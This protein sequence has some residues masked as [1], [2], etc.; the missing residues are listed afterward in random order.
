MNGNISCCSNLSTAGIIYAN[1]DKLIF[2]NLINQYKINLYGINSYGFG[3]A[4]NTLQYSSQNYHNFYNSS[5]NANTFTIDSTG[6]IVAGMGYSA[7]AL[8]NYS[9]NGSPAIS[10]VYTNTVSVPKDAFQVGGGVAKLQYMIS[11]EDCG[12]TLEIH[13]IN[14]N[15]K[16]NQI[17]TRT[18]INTGAQ[19]DTAGTIC[20]DGTNL[21]LCTGNYD[22]STVIWKKITL[23]SI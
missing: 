5:N 19:G 2:P 8:E 16:S 1:G 20:S 9:S 12:T 3:I 23:A 17:T 11:T 15:Q 14:R 4:G 13:P 18:P 7:R 22:G 10:T 6:N 21:Y